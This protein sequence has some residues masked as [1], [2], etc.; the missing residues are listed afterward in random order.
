M[1]FHVFA[2]RNCE[3][4]VLCPKESSQRRIAARDHYGLLS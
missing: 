1:D 2:N 3:I 4:H